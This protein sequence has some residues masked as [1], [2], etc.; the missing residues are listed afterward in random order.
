M[1]TRFQQLG[2]VTVERLLSDLTDIP[3]VQIL[4]PTLPFPCPLAL[5]NQ[6]AMICLM[7]SNIFLKPGIYSLTLL[8]RRL[9]LAP[10]IEFQQN[11]LATVPKALALDAA[12]N[13]INRGEFKSAIELLEQGRAV[14]W[15]KLRDYRHTLDKLRTIEKELFDQFVTLSG[16][17]ECLSNL[18]CRHSS[19][20]WSGL[21]S[22]RKCKSFAFFQRNGTK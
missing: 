1:S 20:T 17:L 12:S 6:G 16:Q 22:E 19:P 3:I 9:I 8:G 14:L 2:H 18:D 5:R 21:L 15:S 4:S 7:Q 13:S 10:T 11:L